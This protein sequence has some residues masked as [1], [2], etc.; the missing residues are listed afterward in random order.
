MQTLYKIQRHNHSVTECSTQM[1]ERFLRGHYSQE[2]TQ[3]DSLL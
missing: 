1:S 3:I 2:L